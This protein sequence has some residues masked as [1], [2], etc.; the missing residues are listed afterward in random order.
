MPPPRYKNVL[1]CNSCRSGGLGEGIAGGDVEFGDFGGYGVYDG[2]EQGFVGQ[3]DGGLATGLNPV[4]FL[5]PSGYVAGL[6]IVCWSGDDGDFLGCL[7]VCVLN[8]ACLV[9]GFEVLDESLFNG[10][11]QIET[12]KDILSVLGRGTL[13]RGTDL[14]F[15]NVLARRSSSCGM[16]S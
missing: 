14:S 7:L 15:E 16:F 4:V 3:D 10:E 9:L 13:G 8:E 2:L 11:E 5:K 1:R 12:G 6:D